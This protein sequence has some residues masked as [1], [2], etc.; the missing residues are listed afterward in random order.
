VI[1]RNSTH[2]AA[3]DFVHK[4]KKDPTQLLILGN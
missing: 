3:Y 4:L 2:G 1:G